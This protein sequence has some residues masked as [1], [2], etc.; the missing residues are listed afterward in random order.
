MPADQRYS[1]VFDGTAQSLDHAIT[2][3]ALDAHVRGAQHARGNA[4]AP[5]AF[6]DD[7]TT[8]LRSSDH[9]GTVLFLTT[10]PTPTACPTT[11]TR[12]PRRRSRRACRRET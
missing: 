4:D 6:A 8:A 5:F 9:D 10:D 12:A 11:S 2:S 1:F 7:G 3:Q